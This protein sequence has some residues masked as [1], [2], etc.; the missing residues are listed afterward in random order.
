VGKCKITFENCLWLFVRLS[1]VP[2]LCLSPL[3]SL[4]MQN[5]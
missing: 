2:S 5:M 4:V 1:A 3:L